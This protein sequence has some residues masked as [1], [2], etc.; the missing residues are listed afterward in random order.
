MSMVL[1]KSAD[2]VVTCTY[3]CQWAPNN[4][5]TDAVAVGCA[6]E[7]YDFSDQA[8]AL[9]QQYYGSGAAWLQLDR[10]PWQSGDEDSCTGYTQQFASASYASRQSAMESMYLA[11]GSSESADFTDTSPEVASI[12]D[13]LKKHKTPIEGGFVAAGCAAG[14]AAGPP[15]W[16]ACGGAIFGWWANK[17]IAPNMT[18]LV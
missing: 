16:I 15:G 2:A 6:N 4:Y 5:V 9:C 13:W 1:F 11:W 17:D 3:G 7:C 10:M 18:V 8:N 12:G 14:A